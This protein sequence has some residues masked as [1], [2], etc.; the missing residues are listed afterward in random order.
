MYLQYILTFLDTQMGYGTFNIMGLDGMKTMDN[1]VVDWIGLSH[2]IVMISL[3][4]GQVS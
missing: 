1:R 2:L 4:S 3:E